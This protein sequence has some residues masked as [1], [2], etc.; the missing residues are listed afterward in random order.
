MKILPLGLV[1]TLLTQLS[2]CGADSE[3]SN[4]TQESEQAAR[5]ILT[6]QQQQALEAANSVE[7]TLLNSAADR[8]KELEVRLRNQ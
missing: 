3:E 1:A 6:N 4:V 8:E 5:G 7:Q 2:A